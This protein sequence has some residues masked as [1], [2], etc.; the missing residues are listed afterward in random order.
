VCGS[1]DAWGSQH[2]A[3]VGSFQATIA[4]GGVEQPMQGKFSIC[5]A[6]DL[7]AP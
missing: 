3:V 4:Q 5:R 6:P 2:R 1:A 7:V